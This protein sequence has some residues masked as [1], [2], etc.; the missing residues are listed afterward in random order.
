[1]YDVQPI[2]NLLTAPLIRGGEQRRVIQGIADEEGDEPAEPA[3]EC[4]IKDGMALIPGSILTAG[5]VMIAKIS[6]EYDGPMTTGHATTACW[7]WHPVK[8]A[9]TQYGGPEHNQR[10]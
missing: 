1:M 3:F 7:E 9:F 10:T 8:H 6:I 4:Q 5:R 2:H